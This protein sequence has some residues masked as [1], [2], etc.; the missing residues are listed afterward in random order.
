MGW[1][2]GMNKMCDLGKQTGH[3]MN[4]ELKS[5]M[6]ETAREQWF[7]RGRWS[8]RAV[9]MKQANCWW[10]TL[11]SNTLQSHWTSMLDLD[12]VLQC[13]VRSYVENHKIE[14]PFGMLKC[15]VVF[16]HSSLHWE[17][18]G[19]L[20]ASFPLLIGPPVLRHYLVA[21]K[22]TSQ[23]FVGRTVVFS[24]KWR[25]KQYQM[26]FDC[27]SFT[28]FYFYYFLSKDHYHT[29]ANC[30]FCSLIFLL[31]KFVTKVGKQQLVPTKATSHLSSHG[32]VTAC[33][34]CLATGD[35]VITQFNGISVQNK[36]KKTRP[37]KQCKFCNYLLGDFFS[38][39]KIISWFSEES[40]IGA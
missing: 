35:F 24:V 13:I 28:I 22:C 29:I 4:G 40:W 37:D 9:R 25:E 1:L 23:D 17:G 15:I 39:W 10:G 8:A 2:S 31:P 3:W 16:E 5:G 38:P 12:I 32:R 11:R 34:P 21:F 6:N 20:A 30:I 7:H 27:H 18:S 19:A 26:T 14:F 33:Q 36:A